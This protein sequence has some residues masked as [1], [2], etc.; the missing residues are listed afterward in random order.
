V[1]HQVDFYL[2]AQKC[3][4]VNGV[5]RPDAYNVQYAVVNNCAIAIQVHCTDLYFLRSE[6]EA[7]KQQ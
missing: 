5:A 4:V 6:R 7:V 1:P 3:G 2:P